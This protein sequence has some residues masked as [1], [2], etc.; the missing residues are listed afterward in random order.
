MK[1][2]T[3]MDLYYT[4][5]NNEVPNRF[6]SAL[7]YIMKYPTGILFHSTLLY[8]TL[9]YSTL[10]YCTLLYCTVLYCTVLYCTVLYCS[11]LTAST[12]YLHLYLYCVLVPVAALLYYHPCRY[13]SHYALITVMVSWHRSHTTGK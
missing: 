7:H 6:Y 8:S 10:F 13:P 2:Q 9:L 3:G 4:S 12:A 1:Y 5:L 11:T